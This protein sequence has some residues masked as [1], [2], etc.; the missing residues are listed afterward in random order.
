[1][2]RTKAQVKPPKGW[3]WCN[4]D[5]TRSYTGCDEFSV[6]ID[7]LVR[8]GRTVYVASVI[9]DASDD[10]TDDRIEELGEFDRFLAAN[11]AAEAYISQR[12]GE[13]I[14]ECAPFDPS[15]G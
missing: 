15:A 11:D 1:M 6:A 9:H 13:P 5:S 8:E 3:R 12:T 7:E 14:P 10:A 4:S 2:T